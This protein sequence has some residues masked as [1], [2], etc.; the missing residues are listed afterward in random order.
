MNKR[1]LAGLA[2]VALMTVSFSS[3]SDEND[4][5]ITPKFTRI[6][7]YFEGSAVAN[8]HADLSYDG[9]GRLTLYNEVSDPGT[10]VYG[11]SFQYSGTDS[12]PIT[13]HYDITDHYF[14]YNADGRLIKDSVLVNDGIGTDFTEV[15]LISYPSNFLI[16]VN[17]STTGPGM[18][19]ASQLRQ[20][21]IT[22][23]LRGN[24]T[25]LKSYQQTPL[26][27][28]YLHTFTTWQYDNNKNPFGQLNVFPVF[29]PGFLDVYFS[30]SN[31]LLLQK[32]N[33]LSSSSRFYD[34]TGT[35]LG[36]DGWTFTPVYE[37]DKITETV[38]NRTGASDSYR[39]VFSYQ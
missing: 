39:Y 29:Q 19:G 8:F 20:D 26:G 7:E 11:L 10:P 28:L 4:D 23:D 27:T 2:A 35:Q 3:C 5:D 36:A 16:V 34:E 14:T 24:A 6:T 37:D 38:A 33:C 22:T 1:N 9:Q 15:R 31:R 17:S 25:Q 12:K 30:M 13:A 18:G 32:N 21:S